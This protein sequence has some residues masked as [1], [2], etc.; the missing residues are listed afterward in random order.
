MV[1]KGSLGGNTY[2]ISRTNK[3]E[4]N[5]ITEN[6][7]VTEVYFEVERINNE[8]WIS[9]YDT[10]MILSSLAFINAQEEIGIFSDAINKV[11]EEMGNNS[12]KNINFEEAGITVT[13]NIEYSGYKDLSSHYLIPE[14]NT[15]ENHF[16]LNFSIEKQS[17]K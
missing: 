3:P 9:S 13:S 12:F 14:E 10:Q 11:V 16:L 4:Y 15:S 6:G 2:S 8:N 7:Y 17:L 1:K 5:F